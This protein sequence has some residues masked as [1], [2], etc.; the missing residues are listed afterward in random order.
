MTGAGSTLTDPLDVD[1]DFGRPSLDEWRLAAEKGL[2]S[3]GLDRLVAEVAESIVVGPLCTE[4]DAVGHA[5][6][7]GLR[8]LTRGSR[9]LGQAGSGWEV[10]QR[11]DRLGR[12]ELTTRAAEEIRGGATGLWIGLGHS[13][14]PDLVAS[15]LESLASAVD[16]TDVALRFDGGGHGFMVA[17]T[18]AAAC[19]QRG[20]D[21]SRLRGSFGWD[22]LGHLATTGELHLDLDTALAMVSELARWTH[23]TAPGMRAVSVDTIP[24]HRAGADPAQRLAIATATAVE[25]L[26]RMTADGLT[27]EAASGQIHF[28]TA[29]G[30]D[31]FVEMAGLRALRRLWSRVTEVFGATPCPRPSIQAVTSP[32]CLSRRDPWVNMLRTTVEAFA[33]SAGGADVITILPYDNALGPPTE[34]GRRIARNAHTVMVEESHLHRIVDPAGGSYLVEWLTDRLARAAWSLFQTIEGQGGMAAALLSGFIGDQLATTADREADALA[35]RR[36]PVTGVSTFANLAEEPPPRRRPATP[37]EPSVAPSSSEPAPK[38][39]Q[40]L[41]PSR[42]GSG[43][44]FEAAVVAAGSG[45]TVNQLVAAAESGSESARCRPL[46]S[47][48]EG[49]RFEVLRDASD[50]HVSLTGARPC[51]FLARFGPPSEHRL[52]ADFARNLLAAGGVETVDGDECEGVADAVAAFTASGARTAVICSSDPHYP[53]LIP[54]VSMALKEAGAHLVVVAGTPGSLEGGWRGTG[55]DAFLYAGCNAVTLLK[56]VLH[57]EGVDVG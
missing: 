16:P 52:G 37:A 33:A 7:P 3:G 29:V 26:R 40:D 41:D 49:E 48:R 11:I 42:L 39:L 14:L 21:M 23:D 28:V 1:R 4:S 34:L 8:P 46:P 50:R 31:F 44:V 45:A 9:P 38:P 36:R 55:V 18:W 13:T 54:A 35:T 32:R 51:V 53:T 2:G 56:T 24:H 47:V 22:P 10:C 30:R 43:G 15:D 19:R 12:E 27:V 25:Y 20:I 17:A 5:G 6:Y 57:T